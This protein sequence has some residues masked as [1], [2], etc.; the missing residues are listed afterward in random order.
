MK[1]HTVDSENSED[2]LDWFEII[3]G[4]DMVR[5]IQ[6]NDNSMWVEMYPGLFWIHPKLYTWFLLKR[7]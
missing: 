4:P 7:T 5:W 6:S 1:L 2:Y 3:P